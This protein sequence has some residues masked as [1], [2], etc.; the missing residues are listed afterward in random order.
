MT[1]ISDFIIN[2]DLSKKIDEIFAQIVSKFLGETVCIF[3]SN[4]FHFN[5]ACATKY[6]SIANHF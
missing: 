5:A 6:F 1:S 4:L 2:F 3:F